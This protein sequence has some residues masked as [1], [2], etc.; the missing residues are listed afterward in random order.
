VRTRRCFL[1][2]ASLISASALVAGS[3][4]AQELN[5]HLDASS[6]RA[7]GGPQGSEFGFGASGA[8]AVELKIARAVGAQVEAGGM[9]LSHGNPSST[10]G[11]AN[12]SDG[13]VFGAM[14]GVRFHPGFV[15][16]FW[17]DA[18]IGAVETGPLARPAFDA[19]VGYDVHFGNTGPRFDIG[20]FVG[21]EQIFEAGNAAFPDDAHIL[22]IGAHV[23]VGPAAPPRAKSQGV[24]M[25]KAEPPPAA[26]LPTEVV[27]QP[28]YTDLDGDGVL[29]MHDACP[30][31][32][33]VATDDAETNG[34]PAPTKLI[35]VRRDELVLFDRI[36]FDTDHARVKAVSYRIVEALADYIKAHPELERVSI[37]GHADE[38]GDDTYNAWLSRARAESVRNLLVRRYQ[39]DDHVVVLKAWGESHPADPGHSERAHTQ[40]RRVEFIV[41]H[42][43]APEQAPATPSNAALS[44]GEP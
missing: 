44:Q 4:D 27:A 16:G 10:P 15:D 29:D 17:L 1:V 23:A 26:P 6:A 37:E 20:P 22:M 8:V 21:Y 43:R 14:G 25:A 5:Y 2:I 35:S 33:G 42:A 19:H 11:V 18:N 32:P 38:M 31:I 12:K 34:C 30:T 13:D 39:V 9:W 3:A 28:V 24:E 7:V 40:N 36:Y 41:T